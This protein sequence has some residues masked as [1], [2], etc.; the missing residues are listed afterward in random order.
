MAPLPPLADPAALGVLVGKDLADDARARALI[1]RASTLV[2]SYTRRSWTVPASDPPTVVDDLPDAVH[3]VALAVAERAY[4]NP[5][6]DRTSV[7]AIGFG[8]TQGPASG[9]DAGIYLSRTDR[10]LLAP[11]VHAPTA[12]AVPGL[13]TIATTKDD[14]SDGTVWLPTAPQPSGGLIPWE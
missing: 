7:Q 9:V 4:R 5:T 3:D 12:G 2:R 11:Y 6:G 14:A 10:D 1:A 13:A 8:M